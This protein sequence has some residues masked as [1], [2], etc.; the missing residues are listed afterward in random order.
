MATGALCLPPV[1][2]LGD[3]TLPKSHLNIL[4]FIIDTD[5]WD[6]EAKL[7]FPHQLDDFD[8]LPVSILCLI[9]CK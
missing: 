5:I 8:W 4:G 6:A 1:L 9:T 3:P 7:Q 2:S